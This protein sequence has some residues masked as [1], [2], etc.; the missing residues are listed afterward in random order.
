MYATIQKRFLDNSIVSKIAFENKFNK[1]AINVIDYY[2]NYYK[3]KITDDDNIIINEFQ[4]YLEDNNLDLNNLDF[5][6]K[7]RLFEENNFIENLL[8]IKKYIGDVFINKTDYYYFILN[9]LIQFPEE[10]KIELLFEHNNFSIIIIGKNKNIFIDDYSYNFHLDIITELN[11]VN[12]HSILRYMVNKITNI[13]E[14]K[15]HETVKVK[16]PSDIKS[17]KINVISNGRRFNVN[18]PLGFNVGDTISVN[19]TNQK[20][21]HNKNRFG[22]VIHEKCIKLVNIDIEEVHEIYSSQDIVIYIINDE[23]ISSH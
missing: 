13:K 6:L 1:F 8:N 11:D 10:F 5:K 17:G 3:Y 20:F 7:I 15:T 14:Y 16:V 23:G 18:C 12:Y 4:I 22:I 9:N 19:L 21:N 2:Q